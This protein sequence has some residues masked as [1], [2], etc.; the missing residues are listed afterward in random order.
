VPERPRLHIVVSGAGG[1][2]GSELVPRL[3]AQGH[4]I[5]RLVRQTAR[6]G[7]IAWD[8]ARGV[9]D[10]AALEGVDAVVHLSGENVGARWTAARKT[11][12]RSSRV[13]STRLLSEALTRL[14]RPPR[15]LIAASAVGIYGNRGDEILT[16]ASSTGNPDRDFL[17][18]VTQDWEQAAAPARAAGVR[19]VHP[20]FG[21]VLSPAGGALKKML[22]PFRLGLG[23]RLGSGRQWMSWVSIDDAAAAIQHMLVTD[24]L[25]GAVNL[26]APEPVTN[27][28]LTRALGQALSRSTPLPVPALALRLVL[29][30]MATSTIL[31]SVRALPARLLESGYRFAHPIIE[32]A[33]RHVLGPQRGANFLP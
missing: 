22:P 6:S 29:G 24:G 26:T 14:R 7:E 5:T 12:I 4:R 3:A 10:P 30:E 9:L 32:D 23:G 25:Q 20:R 21:V 19:V 16:E 17:V 18:S 8:P 1:L 31:A 27:S 15:V 33:L 28:E 11:R 13:G 2:L